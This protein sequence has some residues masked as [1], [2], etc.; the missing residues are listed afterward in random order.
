MEPRGFFNL[1]FDFAF[2]LNATKSSQN[3]AELKVPH[4]IYL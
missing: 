2:F 3:L 1:K 4:T